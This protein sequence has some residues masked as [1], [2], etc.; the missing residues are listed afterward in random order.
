[1]SIAV[2]SKEENKNKEPNK[3]PKCLKRDNK[4]RQ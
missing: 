2:K 3:I 4:Y 1:M